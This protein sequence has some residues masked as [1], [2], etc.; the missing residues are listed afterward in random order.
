MLNCDMI[1]FIA[2]SLV[3]PKQ[4]LQLVKKKNGSR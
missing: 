4:I 1:F 2:I 3:S